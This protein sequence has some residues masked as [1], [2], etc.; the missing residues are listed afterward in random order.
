MGAQ[1]QSRSRLISR[2]QQVQESF[3]TRNEIP[4]PTILPRCRGGNGLDLPSFFPNLYPSNIKTK[5]TSKTETA[6]HTSVM[7]H[8]NTRHESVQYCRG[9]AGGWRGRFQR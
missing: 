9:S 5:S 1:V 6:N 2:H 3:A 4:T 7:P 8:H